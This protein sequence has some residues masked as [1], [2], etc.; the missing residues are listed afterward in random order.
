ML[1]AF[2]NYT[3]RLELGIY[4]FVAVSEKGAG[5]DDMGIPG[6]SSIPDMSWDRLNR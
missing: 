6:M 3:T 1:L 4:R 2:G 5:P